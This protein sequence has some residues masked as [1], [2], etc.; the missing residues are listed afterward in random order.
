MLASHI[1]LQLGFQGIETD[2]ILDAAEQMAKASKG[3]LQCWLDGEFALGAS[4]PEGTRNT[5]LNRAAFR[6]AQL[7]GAGMT[8]LDELYAPLLH[9]AGLPDS[10][11]HATIAS[12]FR[13]GHLHP[14]LA[15][16]RRTG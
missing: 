1:A 11:T 15:G 3:M 6:L 4:A 9:T 13:A 14:R 10:E 5:T 16:P 12:G 2:Q 7:A 8:T